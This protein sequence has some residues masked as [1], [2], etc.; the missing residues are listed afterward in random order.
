MERRLRH[1]PNQSVTLAEMGLALT[2]GSGTINPSRA[3]EVLVGFALLDLLFY[4]HV[5]KIVVCP[6]LLFLLAIVLS[7][8]LLIVYSILSNNAFFTK[9]SDLHPLSMFGMKWNDGYAICQI[10]Q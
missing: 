8:L 9:P 5:L 1:L 6:F 3:P 7:V 2:N 4:V 10:S